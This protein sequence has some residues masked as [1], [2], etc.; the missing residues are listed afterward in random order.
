MDGRIVR[1]NIKMARPDLT[2][3]PEWEP[4]QIVSKV[5]GIGGDCRFYSIVWLTNISPQDFT[6]VPLTAATSPNYALVCM[7][8]SS[9]SSSDT[10]IHPLPKRV[11]GTSSTGRQFRHNGAMTCSSPHPGRACKGQ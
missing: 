3:D 9:L 1:N 8:S 6:T 5:D 7:V 10:S 2:D 4:S 11:S